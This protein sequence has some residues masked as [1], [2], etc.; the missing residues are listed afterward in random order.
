MLAPFLVIVAFLLLDIVAARW[1]VDSRRLG[2][3]RSGKD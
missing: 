3:W 2:D 1:G